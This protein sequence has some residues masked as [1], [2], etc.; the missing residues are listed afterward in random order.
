MCKRL[1]LLKAVGFLNIVNVLFSLITSKTT[2]W[3]F[4]H[5]YYLILWIKNFYL[6]SLLVVYLYTLVTHTIKFAEWNWISKCVNYV[7][8]VSCIILW[9]HLDFISD[10][11]KVSEGDKG[12]GREIQKAIPKANN[13]FYSLLPIKFLKMQINLKK[14]N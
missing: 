14:L 6:L 5:R 3:I 2:D 8:S 11:E 10:S 9:V 4:T 1:K 7:V 13:N 12:G